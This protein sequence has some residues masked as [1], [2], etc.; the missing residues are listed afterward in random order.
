MIDE[1]LKRGFRHMFS[2]N[3]FSGKEDRL[4]EK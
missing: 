4:A 1:D 2:A 3:V